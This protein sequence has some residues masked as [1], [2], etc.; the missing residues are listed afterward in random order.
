MGRESGV[1]CTVKEQGKIRSE[2]LAD[3]EKWL[4]SQSWDVQEP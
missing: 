3:C 1:V 2:A 4:S